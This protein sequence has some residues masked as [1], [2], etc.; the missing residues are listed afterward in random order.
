M[1][2][3]VA[4]PA[5]RVVRLGQWTEQR[6]ADIDQERIVLAIRCFGYE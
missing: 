6:P 4:A 2:W 1:T 3:P 5:G